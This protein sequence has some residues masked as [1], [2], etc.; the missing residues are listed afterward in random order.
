MVSKEILRLAGLNKRKTLLTAVWIFIRN[1]M[2]QDSRIHHIIEC[3]IAEFQW[4]S[5]NDT[6]A[7]QN[8]SIYSLLL[9]PLHVLF[10][11]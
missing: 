7:G 4:L 10:L 11:M 2:E 6:F 8:L 5:G 1:S 3:Y 9:R